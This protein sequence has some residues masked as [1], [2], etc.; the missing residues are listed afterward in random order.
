[1]ASRVR[2]NT[3]TA[4]TAGIDAV[5]IRHFG[6]QALNPAPSRHS[7]N[8][9]LSDSAERQLI[10]LR[11]AGRDWASIAA[12]L[13]GTAVALRQQLSRA[14]SRVSAELGLEGDDDVG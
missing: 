13:G 3:P 8:W 9:R 2:R 7:E 14:I 6:R 12:E 4:A 10:E 11:N 5:K 1:M